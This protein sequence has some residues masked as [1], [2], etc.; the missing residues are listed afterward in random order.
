[1]K[2]K[3]TLRLP[4]VRAL[5]ILAAL[6]ALTF[7]APFLSAQTAEGT[8]TMSGLTILKG[9]A[10][11]RL[12]PMAVCAAIAL[13]FSAIAFLLPK[14]PLV[15]CITAALSAG[16]VSALYALFTAKTTADASMLLLEPFMVRQLGIGLW[17]YLILALVSLFVAMAAM[18]QPSE[19]IV[20]T[21]MA[22]FWLLPIVWLVLTAFRQEPGAYTPYLLPKGYTLS[23]FTRL[24]TETTQFNFP[25][26]YLNTLIVAVLT[27]LITTMLVLMVAYTFSR[28]RFPARKKLMNIG[29]ILGMFPGFMSMIA[30]YHLLKAIGLSQS[31]AALVLV[32]SSGGVLNYFIAKGFFDTIPRSLDEAATIDGASKNT[33]FW[34]IILPSSQPIVVYTAITAFIA[35]WVDFI[36]VSVIMKDDYRNYTVALGLFKMLEREHLYEYFTRFC[37]GAVLVAIPITLL[38]IKIQ[39]FYV[40][41]VTGGAV[42][43]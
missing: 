31:L 11:L 36:F 33:V 39:K 8:Q 28:L 16:V 25:R 3:Q 40:E 18:R 1:M 23:N 22:S 17:L 26:W 19:Y 32:Y 42:K 10:L 41:G 43:G 13:L 34:K 20:L 9:D 5:V 12:M 24:F 37:A 35:P 4:L 27:C 21:I 14:K 38:F 29:L 15:L 2:K 6:M 7:L 30:I